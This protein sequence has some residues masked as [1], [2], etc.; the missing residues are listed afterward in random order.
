MIAVQ[1]HLLRGT[2]KEGEGQMEG[3]GVRE[4]RAGE[5]YEIMNKIYR[6]DQ[7]IEDQKCLLICIKI[8]RSLCQI[9]DLRYDLIDSDVSSILAY[10]A[11][12]KIPSTDIFIS[13]LQKTK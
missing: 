10:K 11:N 13:I 12:Q 6:E 3:E 5:I 8:L 2:G 4:A 7:K 1:D 9:P